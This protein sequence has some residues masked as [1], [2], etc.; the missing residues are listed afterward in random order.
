V[1]NGPGSTPAIAGELVVA[2]GSGCRLQA[3]S[4][5]DGKPAWDVDVAGS[6]KSRFATRGGCSI[7]P[8]VHGGLVVLPTGATD[9]ERLVAFDAVTGK[10]VWSA[11]G[12][13]R[14]INTNPSFWDAAGGA[15]LLYHYMK[16]PGESGVTGVNLKDGSTA[17]SVAAASGMSN[18]APLPLGAGRLLLQMWSGSGVFETSGAAAPRQVWSNDALTAA[19][20][21]AVFADGHLY[22][23]WGNSGEFFKCVDATSGTVRW[24]TR[25]YRG[26]AIVAGRTIV[27]QSESSGLLRLVAADPAAYR[28]LT[29]MTVLKPG[30]ATLAPPSIAGG[31]IFVRD[32]EEIVAVRIQ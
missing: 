11:K 14:S 15:Q 2:L 10:P 20:V 13:E 5:A 23:F 28:E 21:P 31:L 17:W 8:V 22:G 27:I 30:A 6:Y 29:K 3:F 18:T 24:S 4:S 1:T 19:A 12:V 9:G 25:I 7:P 16:P 26:T 32:L